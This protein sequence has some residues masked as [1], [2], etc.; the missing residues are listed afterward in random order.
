MA[1][2][3][4]I[5]TSVIIPNVK[6]LSKDYEVIGDPQ[7]T[8]LGKLRIDTIAYKYTWQLECVYLIPTEYDDVISHLESVNYGITDFWLDE[9]DGNAIDDSIQALI[10]VASDERVQFSRGGSFYNDGHTIELEVRE[11]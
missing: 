8:A 7:R 10:N 1:D 5:G 9:F 4:V 3:A 11:Q 2:T 6:T